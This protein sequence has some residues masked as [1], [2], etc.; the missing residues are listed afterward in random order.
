MY[1]IIPA[2]GSVD[3]QPRVNLLELGIVR[4]QHMPDHAVRFADAEELV[5]VASEVSRLHPNLSEEAEFVKQEELYRRDA[6]AQSP[7]VAVKGGNYNG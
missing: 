2:M 6:L 1:L 3:K 7:L 4:A 5:R